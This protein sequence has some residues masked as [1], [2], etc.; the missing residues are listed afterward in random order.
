LSGDVK[1]F[2]VIERTMYNGLISGLSLDGVKFFY[3]NALESDGVYKFNQG[4]C[5]RKDWFDCSCCPTNL[6]RFIPSIPGLIYSKTSNGIYVNLYASNEANI[7]LDSNQIKISQKTNYPWDGNV[8][9]S[10]NPEQ[11]SEFSIKLR[12]PGWSRNEVLSGDLYRY[13]N[14]SKEKATLKINGE[15]VT[16][17][18]KDGYFA[19]TR[20]WNKNDTIELNFP[21][22]VREVIANDK[23]KDD[24]GKVALEYGP[25]VYAIEDID[26]PNF[27]A[28]S[29]SAADTFTVQREPILEGVNTLTNE[30]LK[31]VPY[32]AWSNRGIGKMKVWLPKEETSDNTH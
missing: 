32:Y 3:P 20:Q 14:P 24:N 15:L 13:L 5:T 30:K 10:V 12:I 21:M 28:I 6:I 23:V 29:V 19:I 2:D 25:I 11:T 17:I 7:N 22:E 1:Y 9:I 31:A 8:S 18:E 16:A 27:D 4:A 26:N